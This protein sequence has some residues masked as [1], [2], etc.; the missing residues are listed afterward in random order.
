LKL[1]RS[2]VVVVAVAALEACAEDAP[3]SSAPSG[4]PLS[5]GRTTVFDATKGAYG[6]M[7]P[8]VKGSRT[9]NF[10]LGHSLFTRNWVT[11][12]A[13]TEDL[14][15]LG[16]V[17]NQRSCSSCHSRD[18]RAP[19]FDPRGEMLGML[20]RISIPGTD[21]HGGP[22]GDPTYATQIRPNAILG[23]PAEATGHVAY[24]EVPGTYEDGTPYSLR[25]PSVTIDGWGYGAPTGQLLISPRVAPITIGLGLLEAI[26][27]SAILANVKANDPD[28]V[29]GHANHVWDQAHGAK[30]LGRFGWK[31]NVPSVR[32]QTAGAFVGDMGITSSLFPEETC[33]APMT[34]CKA[35]Q[36]GGAPEISDAHLAAV[37]FYME[38]L[39]VPARRAV[40]DEAALRGEKLFHAFGSASC[41]ADTFHTGAFPDVPEVEN[42]TIHPYSDLL[43]HDMGPDLADGR[44]DYE[45]NG[46]EWRTPP[47]W[48]LGLLETVNDH[49]FLLHDARA[50]GVAE[51]ILW[52]GG[53]GAAA[54]ERFR[55]ASAAD[56]DALVVFLHSL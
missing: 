36:N 41:H 44:P 38:T 4:D 35:A 54:R 47:L 18:G 45:A 13:T 27:E 16:P 3:P 49:E 28:G 22:A 25:R 15:G 1:T 10:T 17:F 52:H 50:R 21:P 2:L 29:V 7:S 19:P 11:A 6:N 24:E 20:L 43:L 33:T 39:A 8:T 37:V 31:A 30:A 42:Q 51:A 32:Q 12:P 23:I 26:P 9:D 34:A 40:T 56:R 55:K 48:G 5:G 14:D 46:S 53:E